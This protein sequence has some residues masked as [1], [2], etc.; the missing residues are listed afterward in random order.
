MPYEIFDPSSACN[1]LVPL[2][3][4]TNK[5]IF[6]KINVF[7][8]SLSKLTDYP[9]GKIDGP[10]SIRDFGLSIYRLGIP[11]SDL[12]P[13]IR[14]QLKTKFIKPTGPGPMRVGIEGVYLPANKDYAKQPEIEEV[15]VFKDDLK[16]TS[17]TFDGVKINVSEVQAELEKNG[18]VFYKKSGKIF[19]LK[20]PSSDIMISETDKSE[21]GVRTSF[22]VMKLSKSKLSELKENGF[23]K[24]N[25]KGNDFRLTVSDF[26]GLDFVHPGVQKFAG[27]PAQ[28][29]DFSDPSKMDDELYFSVLK[30]ILY[31]E[32]SGMKDKGVHNPNI[33]SSKLEDG[34]YYELL[35]TFR[36]DPRY[37]QYIKTPA[38]TGKLPSYEIGLYT[39]FE[40]NWEL[41]G[42]SRGALLNSITLAPKEELTIEVF[43]FDRLKLEQE[44]EFTT[45]FE[46][47]L[48]ITS[49]AKASAEISRDFSTTTDVNADVGLGIPLPI[50]G[51]P[52]KLDV[53]GGVSQ[54]VKDGIQTTINHINEV[55]KSSSEKF[56][57]KNRVK[58]VQTRET[59]EE[60]RTTRKIVNP[61]ASRTLT[62]NYFE[63]LETYKVTTDIVATDMNETKRFCLLVDNPDLG[64]IDISF[65]LAYEDRLQKSL[66]SANY[67]AGFEA[68]KKLAAQRW[69]DKKSEIKLEIENSSNENEPKEEA[70]KKPIVRVA[71]NLKK[72]LKKFLHVDLLGAADVLS[73]NVDPFLPDDQKPSKKRVS[74]AEHELGRFNFW[75]K[76]KIA[77]PGVESKAADF[78]ANVNNSV[79]EAV[80][81]EQLELFLT[82]MDDEWLTAVKMIAINLVAVQLSTTLFIPFPLLA[83]L[84]LE[85]ALIS[86][87]EGLP[88]MIDKAKAELKN[89]EMAQSASAGAQLAEGTDSAS[90]STA[91]VPPS[92]PQ[93]FSLE[94]LAL[95]NAEF[96][97]LVLHLE[98]NKSYYI[99]KMLLFEDSNQRYERLKI[100]GIV[101][102]V[103]NRILGFVGNKTVFP[104]RLET[105]DETTVR[106]LKK[107][108]AAF[109]PKKDESIHGVDAPKVEP[110]EE[111]ISLPTA[112]VH[113]ESMLGKCD[114]LEQYL[115]DRR[116]IEQQMAQAQTDM[117]VEK[118]NQLKQENA[119]LAERIRQ[120]ILDKPF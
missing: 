113:V 93:L 45:E 108:L 110:T 79:D 36:M 21:T 62:L 20:F 47:N 65:V 95:A 118:V 22:G 14:E 117:A 102:H 2:N 91:P 12:F 107:E 46:K 30:A 13:H 88:K 26:K 104:L 68:A 115:L 120:G 81:A 43:S 40:Q 86:N 80:A 61:N 67:L 19:K 101:N 25:F 92:P 5:L 66:L 32:R 33:D 11:L 18:V 56:K 97:K 24:L 42:Y 70:P 98:V 106:R 64:A 75:F 3:K 44:K 76:F 72:K 6:F 90:M 119:R 60:T 105:L 9:D 63:L 4:I 109:D 59:G 38:G 116:V 89:F 103:E 49:L 99:N 31:D 69:F 53:S 29:P 100:K 82:G 10:V 39:L 55:T 50:E 15:D 34:K 112:G 52:V 8:I 87:D 27:A 114:A 23:L 94:E 16:K 54:Q 96:E 51:V 74:N 73:K 84:F 78:V 35:N 48:E 85:L 17:I 83:P 28:Q 1:P 37:E 41:Q 77:S 111:S 7:E 71:L 58:I 57:S